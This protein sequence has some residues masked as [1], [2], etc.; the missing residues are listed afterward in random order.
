MDWDQGKKGAFKN[1]F[2]SF[3]KKENMFHWEIERDGILF[4]FYVD[5]D[6]HKK[7]DQEIVDY[8]L[9]WQRELQKAEKVA[10][11]L[12]G[13]WKAHLYLKKMKIHSKYKKHNLY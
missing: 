5:D 13:K 7:K 6:F 3:E 8:N 11:E 4:D 12:T 9:A 2:L 1:Q 10:G